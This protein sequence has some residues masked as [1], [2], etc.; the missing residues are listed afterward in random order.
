MVSRPSPVP[1]LVRERV[2]TVSEFATVPFDGAHGLRRACMT[3]R[4]DAEV[5]APADEQVRWL[6]Q[7]NGSARPTQAVRETRCQDAPAAPSKRA[8]GH[9]S[10]IAGH[11][12]DG[13]RVYWDALRHGAAGSASVS[14][15]RRQYTEAHPMAKWACRGFNPDTWLRPCPVP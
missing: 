7:R 13:R 9:F 10:L 12:G 3:G 4:C 2:M 6:R 8:R 14:R 5:Q 1:L 11:V 15:S